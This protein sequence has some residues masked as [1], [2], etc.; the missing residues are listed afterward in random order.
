MRLQTRIDARGVR[1]DKSDQWRM[2]VDLGV[3]ESP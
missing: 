1:L 3:L 2:C